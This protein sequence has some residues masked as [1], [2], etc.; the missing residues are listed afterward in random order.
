MNFQERLQER[1]VTHPLPFCLLPTPC[2]LEHRCDRWR[3]LD[4]QDQ[5][6]TCGEEEQQLEGVMQPNCLS[7]N[8]LPLDLSVGSELPTQLSHCCSESASYCRA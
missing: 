2:S 3:C 4:H 8:H 5:G 6:R 7:P 1:A